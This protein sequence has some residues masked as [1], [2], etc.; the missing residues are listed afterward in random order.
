M[1]T[2]SL[3]NDLDSIKKKLRKF[4]I[5][6]VHKDLF[7]EKEPCEKEKELSEI[8]RKLKL[9]VCDV[10]KQ[11][12]AIV[13]N[14]A[15]L[16]NHILTLLKN[17]FDGL[18]YII[19]ANNR[20]Y[21]NQWMNTPPGI[22]LRKHLETLQKQK[23]VRF[24]ESPKKSSHKEVH[25]PKKFT[26][27]KGSTSPKEEDDET[28][29][30]KMI[31]LLEESKKLN[32]S[33]HSSENIKKKNHTAKMVDIAPEDEA[34]SILRRMKDENQQKLVETLI[35]ERNSYKQNFYDL[36]L[37]YGIQKDLVDQLNE[38][39]RGISGLAGRT[40]AID[41]LDKEK[42]EGDFNMA[43]EVLQNNIYTMTTT[44]K[45]KDA[46]L[47]EKDSH[48][49]KLEN[50]MSY[51]N[52]EKDDLNEKLKKLIEYD[53]PHFSN[54]VDKIKKI[55]SFDSQ[56]AKMIKDKETLET[57]KEM[58]AKENKTLEEEIILLKNGNKVGKQVV[59]KQQIK[60]KSQEQKCGAQND[61]IRAQNDLIRAQKEMIKTL[62]FYFSGNNY[63]SVPYSNPLVSSSFTLSPKYTEKEILDEFISTFES[64][65]S[66]HKQKQQKQEEPSSPKGFFQSF[67]KI[68]S[69]EKGQDSVDLQMDSISDEHDDEQQIIVEDQKQKREFSSVHKEYFIKLMDI[70]EEECKKM[71]SKNMNSMVKSQNKIARKIFLNPPFSEHQ[72][73]FVPY[74]NPLSVPHGNALG[75]LG[76]AF[77]FCKKEKMQNEIDCNAHI[78]GKEAQKNAI[79]RIKDDCKDDRKKLIT[80]LNELFGES[81]DTEINMDSLIGVIRN[82]FKKCNKKI[83][84][85]DGENTMLLELIETQKTELQKEEK[86]YDDL[87]IKEYTE[88][89]QKLHSLEDQKGQQKGQQTAKSLKEKIEER[90]Q[91]RNEKILELE[92]EKLKLEE[93]KLNL[94]EENLNLEEEK[95]KLK[96]E[97]SLEIDK[98]V[99]EDMKS[100][101]KISDPHNSLPKQLSTY[102]QIFD[103]LKKKI[104]SLKSEK[105][106][107]STKNQML[108]RQYNEEKSRNDDL[109][110]ENEDLRKEKII[111][112][113]SR[114]SVEK[115]EAIPIAQ[116]ILKKLSISDMDV[117]TDLK[118]LLNTIE[119]G[120]D[121]IVEEHLVLKSKWA[122]INSFYKINL[123]YMEKMSKKLHGNDIATPPKDMMIAEIFH[124]RL[125]ELDKYIND[126]M[127]EWIKY[128]N[129]L[130]NLIADP[131]KSDITK[132]NLWVLLP[133]VVK[134][135]KD[136]NENKCIKLNRDSYYLMVEVMNLFKKS[137]EH[138]KMPKDNFGDIGLLNNYLRKL[139]LTLDTQTDF[140]LNLVQSINPF[141]HL[142][143]NKLMGLKKNDIWIK[144][145]EILKYMSDQ[146]K[147]CS[148]ENANI[149]KM[150]G[151]T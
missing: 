23:K 7:G 148:E 117:K 120:I 111:R 17:T 123:D 83:R 99:L 143:R 42:H 128:A 93:E 44:I 105:E 135:L 5:T 60:M 69:S 41:L 109:K 102:K 146:Y 129:A 52:K 14:D 147:K 32:N 112:K 71:Q 36:Q 95:L 127:D 13:G 132:D 106:T 141:N 96:E 110:K 62:D 70:L 100:L 47:K 58:L 45:E 67:K 92:K 81:L 104:T 4:C 21:F 53:K 16:E 10:K 35:R 40:K 142:H 119:K 94:E 65:L 107:L 144:L 138:M 22:E 80:E 72:W 11:N 15:V 46:L 76:D 31:L 64:E 33:L 37:K 91:E 150:K 137:D 28:Q 73:N 145:P 149:K 136:N 26:I 133:R 25:S 3:Q 51:S 57:D 48:I 9:F 89:Y 2:F 84:Q 30:E 140:L 55:E 20:Y 63:P 122:K 125:K 85:M 108:N 59:E 78:A 61:L 86:K 77:I 19:L 124:Y 101:I 134:N 130:N 113:K 39:C 27:F 79:R 139:K 90:L 87:L 97:K 34:I 50:E 88:I 66:D 43:R 131:I 114:Y 68:F 12:F 1:S 38:K 115:I 74:G 118:D 82:E 75:L 151:L 24:Q 98:K 126:K 116:K 56:K 49:Q 18:G 6:Y 29:N 8:V 121:K 54:L 103:I